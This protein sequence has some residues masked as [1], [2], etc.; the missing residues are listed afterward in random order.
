MKNYNLDETYIINPQKESAL[1]AK[2]VTVSYG[3]NHVIHAADLN[4]PR[5]KITSLIGASGSGKSTYLRCFNRMND[6]IA[7]VGG[8]IMYRD[9]DINNPKNQR[10]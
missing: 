4:F 2:Q 8:Q 3:T 6:K 7:T 5:Y 1:S 10:L 9:T